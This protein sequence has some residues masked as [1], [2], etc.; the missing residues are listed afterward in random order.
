M[1]QV[2]DHRIGFDEFIPKGFQT[3]SPGKPDPKGQF[4][5]NK[6]AGNYVNGEAE[7]VQGKPDTLRA[8]RHESREEG[9]QVGRRDERNRPDAGGNQR[10]HPGN[11]K[12][13]K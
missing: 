3:D 11:G 2:E 10:E 4:E 12:V 6:I 13:S 8:G 5:G 7:L 9:E 1:P